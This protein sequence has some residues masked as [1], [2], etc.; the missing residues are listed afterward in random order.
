[1]RNHVHNVQILGNVTIDLFEQ[2]PQIRNDFSGLPKH[3]ILTKRIKELARN[4]LLIHDASKINTELKFLQNNHIT[5]PGIKKLYQMYGKPMAQMSEGEKQVIAKQIN[6]VD[7]AVRS[8]FIL[9]NHVTAEEMNFLDQLEKIADYTERGSNPVT[10]EEIGKS[11]LHASDYLAKD[12][13][14]TTSLAKVAQIVHKV[15]LAKHLELIYPKVA[16]PYAQYR[17]D[18]LSFKSIL[19]ELG[20][21]PQ[22]FRDFSVI[23]LFDHYVG[24]IKHQSKLTPAGVAKFFLENEK[25]FDY[26]NSFA[27]A[28]H[29]IGNSQC[30]KLF[31]A[32]LP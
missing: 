3:F 27:L 32:I 9:S 22:K 19:T 13:T 10:S 7:S 31:G 14:Q 12:L 15:D 11:A 21:E 17:S 6:G 2:N 8:N 23:D 1:M 18:V 24:S 16:I 25:E 26:L 29:T 30:L 20:F 28:P 5:E 4:F